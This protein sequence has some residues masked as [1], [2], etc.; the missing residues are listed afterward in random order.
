MLFGIRD[1]R[2]GYG[3]D[4]FGTFVDA[5][6]GARVPSEP[7]RGGVPPRKALAQ[8][9]D[10]RGVPG[11]NGRWWS[12]PSI[13]G[14]TCARA[15]TPRRSLPDTASCPAY[16][17]GA[18]RFTGE[19]Q[20]RPVTGVGLPGNDRLRREARHRRH[21][22]A[23]AGDEPAGPVTR[24]PPGGWP[25]S[26]R[27]SLR[28]PGR[29]AGLVMNGT[30][31]A[32]HRSAAMRPVAR[33]PPAKR[34]G[35]AGNGFV[36]CEESSTIGTGSCFA[37]P[38]RVDYAPMSRR[39]DPPSALEARAFAVP[40]QLPVPG[41]IAIATGKLTPSTQA[42]QPVH[43]RYLDTFDR[44]L[45]RTDLVLGARHAPRRNM[46]ALPGVRPAPPVSWRRRTRPS[47]RSRA[48]RLPLPAALA[49]LGLDRRPAAPRR[50]RDPGAG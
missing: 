16:W 18:V 25:P 23:G 50:R 14:W 32:L 38:T 7:G 17:E 41:I 49:A 40:R 36:P 43:V 22:G 6:G 8:P 33:A 34:R 29:N 45:R 9:G 12:R 15:S 48:R 2:G 39:S 4:T 5:G 31:P 37:A 13:C 19:R 28:A 3:P 20:G 46:A 24:G 26:P 27:P 11:W 21:R 47:P 44:R 35:R 10:R 42:A 1:A 30:L